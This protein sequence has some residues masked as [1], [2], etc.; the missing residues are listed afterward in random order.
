MERGKIVKV[1]LTEEDREPL[2][3]GMSGIVLESPY[4]G[5]Y[6]DDKFEVIGTL[7]ERPEFL[8]IENTRGRCFVIPKDKIQLAF[9]SGLE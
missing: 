3:L 4:K 5:I 6:D 9:E 7:L 1:V 2:D 8:V